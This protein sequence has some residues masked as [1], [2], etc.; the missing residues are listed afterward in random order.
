[1]WGLGVP[2][3]GGSA[4]S[5][6]L[7]PP[8]IDPAPHW[9][10]GAE[11]VY[12]ANMGLGVFWGPWGGPYMGGD[13]DMGVPICGG[14]PHYQPPSHLPK[15]T[16]HR[17]ESM[18][19]SS[20]IGQIWGAGWGSFGV[21]GGVPIWGSLLGSPPPPPAPPAPQIAH[22]ANQWG[23]SIGR[24]YWRW[25]GGG[26]CWG[27]RPHL[28]PPKPPRRPTEGR[29]QSLHRA[30]GGRYGAAGAAAAQ[31]HGEEHAGVAS[32]GAAPQRPALVTQR[33]ISAGR[34]GGRP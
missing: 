29:P 4:P 26:A 15:S 6:P 8:Q 30:V 25:G 17:I 1:M 16:L 34:L 12:R 24:L 11:L 28:F 18:G 10:Y 9:I 20:S 7:P 33:P 22:A 14:G 27:S 3:W 21:C 23:P 31:S 2:M 32:Y 5:P 13:P 19:Q